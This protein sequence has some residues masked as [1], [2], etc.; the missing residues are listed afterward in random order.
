MVREARHVQ[1]ASE[2]TEIRQLLFAEHSAWHSG[3][4]QDHSGKGMQIAGT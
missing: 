4:G 1:V 2:G 3:V